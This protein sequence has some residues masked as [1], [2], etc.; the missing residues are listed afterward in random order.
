VVVLLLPAVRVRGSVAVA[1]G[2]RGLLLLLLLVVVVATAVVTVVAVARALVVLRR[3]RELALVGG[4]WV[5]RHAAAALRSPVA[6]L[7]VVPPRRR[8]RLA[9]ASR[10]GRPRRRRRRDSHHGPLLRVVEAVR[11][12]QRRRRGAL[13]LAHLV[14]VDRV[15]DI[16]VVPG[17]ELWHRGSFLQVRRPGMSNSK[18]SGA[19]ASKMVNKLCKFN[20]IL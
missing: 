10:G 15:P 8:R 9:V 2:G 14:E 6:A 16:V 12:V 20:L 3:R 13:V 5:G 11:P 7:P 19:N 18:L 4:A 17:A 1:V